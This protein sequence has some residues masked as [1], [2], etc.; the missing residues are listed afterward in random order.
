VSHPSRF[1]RGSILA[2]A[3]VVAASCGGGG[4]GTPS[5]PSGGSGAPSAP[6][7]L[8]INSQRILFTSN[9]VSLA[10]DGNGSSYRLAAG[11]APGGSESLSVEVTGNSYNWSAPR[12]EAV[13]FFRV[14][15]IA[16]GQTSNSSVELP[17]YTADMRN[18]IDALFFR[19][20]PMS[21]DQLNPASNP[22][23]YVWPDGTRVRVIVS[24]EAGEPTRANAQRFA[25][26]YASI[27]GGAITATT[28]MT[29]D[30]FTNITQLSQVPPLT[31]YTRVLNPFCGAGAIA[32]AFYGPPP[33]GPN[34]SIITLAAANNGPVATEHEMGHVYGLGHVRSTAALRQDINFMMNPSYQVQHMSDPEKTAIT[35]A[36]A[37]GMRP[38]WR[39]NEALAA[40]LVLS[41]P[42]ALIPVYGGLSMTSG[43]FAPSRC[44][45]EKAEPWR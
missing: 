31:V 10:W 40:G 32:C 38:G 23:G 29:S 5:G 13:Y 34:N 11:T 8:R 9:E 43:P 28:E 7:N 30:T 12:T 25:D 42:T 6:T 33:L 3:I 36:R 1:T 19:S 2:A 14:Q 22:T 39:R 35:V 17:I 45:I 16:N 44:N 27:A 41:N 15:A 37:N 21:V 24:N 26:D 20:G 4:G 18:I